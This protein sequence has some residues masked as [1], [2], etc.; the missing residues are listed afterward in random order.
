MAVT[1]WLLLMLQAQP[2]SGNDAADVY[3]NYDIND[4]PLGQVF[5]QTADGL[6]HQH[7]AFAIGNMSFFGAAASHAAVVAGA[8][9]WNSVTTTSQR[10]YYYGADNN[11]SF[12]G[13]QCTWPNVWVL[14]A[15]TPTLDPTVVGQF[16]KC[17]QN[18]FNQNQVNGG[19]ILFN[20]HPIIKVTNV[21][22]NASRYTSTSGGPA[23][24]WRLDLASISTHELGHIGGWTKHSEVPSATA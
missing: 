15:S 20:T 8:N 16:R 10:F 3:Q 11:V 4:G 17:Q 21:L 23:E 18:T 12:S 1:V 6:T 9:Q 5:Y 19:V 2:A 24:A 22:V 7:I 14:Q 13:N